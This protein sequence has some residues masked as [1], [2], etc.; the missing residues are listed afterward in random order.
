MDAL[1]RNLK[2]LGIIHR[3]SRISATQIRDRLERDYGI[4]TTLRTIQRDLVNLETQFPLECDDSRPAGWR[5]AEHAP[6]FDIPNMDLVAALAFSLVEKHIAQLLPHSVL[7]ALNPYFRTAENRM[8]HNKTDLS[9][10]P[11]KVRVASRTITHISPDVPEVISDT[12]YTALMEN[13]R[14]KAEYRK[15]GNEIKTYE[16]SPLGM[17]VVGRLTYLIVTLYEFK[18]PVLL[19]LHRIQKAELLEKRI[20]AP[21]GFDL[22]AYISK[23]L[24]FPLGENICLK[25]RFTDSHDIQRLEEAP[26]SEDQKIH[27][28]DDGR[29]DLTATLA[30]TFKVR[31]WLR[32]YGDYVEVL[33]PE[34]LRKE[35]AEMEDELKKMYGGIPVENT[36]V[37][38]ETPGS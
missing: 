18:N 30:D 2:I 1:N 11:D 22:D 4:E 7:K 15:L 37:I 24:P 10:W 32:E 33:E 12:V 25:A 16:V 23:E 31:R 28:L 5:W 29:F 14:F 34:A 19:L 13:R 17:A 9:T 21:D 6:A 8:K 26:V 3:R 38:S 35:F 36:P 20:T 27:R